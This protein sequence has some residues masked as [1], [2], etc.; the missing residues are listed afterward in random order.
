MKKQ[1]HFFADKVHL[2]TAMVFPAVRYG[3]DSCIIKKVENWRFDAF[4]LWCWKRLSRV[5]WTARSN[6]SILRE[7]NSEYSLE[8]LMLNLTLQQFGNLMWKANSLE[9]TLMLG[10]TERKRR[11]GQRRMRCLDGI[12]NSMDMSL[13][14][15]EETVKDREAWCAACS[16]WCCKES[17]MTEG[18]NNNN[19]LR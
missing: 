19:K 5:P 18:L 15:L 9:T 16:P 2:V 1:R 11:S 12:T 3:C 10:K 8:G 13:K 7:I 14:K 6:Q 4:E 17:N